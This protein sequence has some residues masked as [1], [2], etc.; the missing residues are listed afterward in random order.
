MH[1]RITTNHRTASWVAAQAKIS[2]SEK[3]GGRK[4]VRAGGERVQKKNPGGKRLSAGVE[5]LFGSYA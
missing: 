4:T 3:I 5:E 2:T 1:T